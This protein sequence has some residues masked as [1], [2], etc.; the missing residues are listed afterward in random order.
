MTLGGAL[1]AT[2]MSEGLQIASLVA[3]SFATS[4]AIN[5]YFKVPNPKTN[6]EEWKAARNDNGANPLTNPK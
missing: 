5:A 6:T 3:A 1:R 2:G 4:A